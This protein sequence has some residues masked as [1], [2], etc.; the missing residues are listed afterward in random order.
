MLKR[1]GF[2]GLA[3]EI[4]ANAEDGVLQLLDSATKLP[5]NVEEHENGQRLKDASCCNPQ[6]LREGMARHQG[7]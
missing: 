5:N 2:I 3:T 7:T 6:T 1:D 4:A